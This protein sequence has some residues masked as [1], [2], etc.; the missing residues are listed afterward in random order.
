MFQLHNDDK[1]KTVKV[2]FV[3]F[4]SDFDKNN[5]FLDILKTRYNVEISDEPDYLF[6]SVFG[7]KHLKYRECIRIFYTGECLTP[8]FNECDY[9]IGFDRLVFGDRYLRYPLYALFQY[10]NAYNAILDRTPITQEELAAKT[11]FCSFVVSNGFAQE[12]RAKFFELLSEYKKVNSGG[13]FRNNIGGA[14]IDKQ[15]FQVKHKFSLAFENNSYQGYITEKIGEA[16]ASRTI[17]IYWGDPTIC[18]D[19]NDEAF[20]NVHNYASFADVIER[21]KELDNDDEKYLS[22]VNAPIIKNQISRQAL[23]QFLFNIFDQ[24]KVSAQRRPLSKN[25]IEFEKMQLRHRFFEDKIYTPYRRFKSL[26]SQLRNGTII[27]K[28]RT[29]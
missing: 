24:E 14:I 3:D 13:R 10:K 26:V 28:K 25:Q 5:D 1:M 8:D 21:I 7:T 6:Y 17:P 4:H 11:E 22:V 2:N 16:F 23:E 9:A 27:S 20:V 18:K 19:F 29:E 15:S 12:A